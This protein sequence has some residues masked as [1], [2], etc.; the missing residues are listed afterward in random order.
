MAEGIAVGQT[1]SLLVFQWP[2]SLMAPS[3]SA[4]APRSD[5]LGVVDPAG[6]ALRMVWPGDERAA[7]AYLLHRRYGR[8]ADEGRRVSLAPDEFAALTRDPAMSRRSLQKDAERAISRALAASWPLWQV[9]EAKRETGCQ[10]PLSTLYARYR[11]VAHLA[12][13]HSPTDAKTFR[14]YRAQF[15]S[16]LPLWVAWWA[17]GGQSAADRCDVP[18]TVEEVERAVAASDFA[19]VAAA[20]V[21]FLAEAEHQNRA[22]T[23]LGR[24]HRGGRALRHSAGESAFPAL[25]RRG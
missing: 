11:A 24:P 8:A 4:P 9:W 3:Q 2:A 25:P 13:L 16:V 15:A 18:T 10:P 20:A 12:G 22:G 19:A 6:C 17:C 5:D 23:L 14:A 7:R 1:P 21:G